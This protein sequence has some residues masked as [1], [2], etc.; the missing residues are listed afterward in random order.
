[1][2][3]SLVIFYFILLS[4]I[5]GLS[6]LLINRK[7]KLIVNRSKTAILLEQIKKVDSD[8]STHNIDSLK[9]GIINLDKLL[10]EAIRARNVKGDTFVERM[11]AAEHL[12]K[13]KK[14]Y[15]QTWEAHKVRNRIV[16]DTD[17]VPYQQDLRNAYNVLLSSITY[18][19]KV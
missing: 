5:I 16:H 11:K 2:Q 12:F 6:L 7:P 19:L 14:N 17:F 4:T 15:Q 8:I 10:D 3:A 9:L 18:L 1:M 13:N